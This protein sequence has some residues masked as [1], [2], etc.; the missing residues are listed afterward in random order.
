M[1]VTSKGQVTIPQ[2]VRE[3]CGIYP[4]ETEVEFVKD[5]NN[6]W[7]LHKIPASESS[8]SRFRQAHKAGKLRMTTDELMALTRSN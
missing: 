8:P 7:Y 3:D 6:R 2:F 1:K 4:A 5:K